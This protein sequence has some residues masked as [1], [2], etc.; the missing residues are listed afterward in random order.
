MPKADQLR[1][2]GGKGRG[3]AQMT[4][5]GLPVPPGFTI[6]TEV[7]AAF[8]QRGQW[9]AELRA[10]VDQA[11]GA[12]EAQTGRTF[13]R[14]PRPLLLSVRSGAATSMPGMM[15]TV[16]NLG[17]DQDT[18][19][20]LAAL[21]NDRR[22]ALDAYRRLL[23]MY[24]DVV[25]GVPHD[26]FERALTAAKHKAGRADMR[27]ADLPEPE[28]EAL[29][30]RYKK[31][32]AE[33]CGEPINEDPHAQ[34]WLAIAA[35][36]RSWNNTRA[37]RYRAMM[38]IEDALGTACTV[39]AMVFGNLG[40]RSG[41]G[42]AFT[43]NPSNGARELYGEF[44]TDAQGED[45]VAGLRTPQPL[46]ARAAMPG[47][48]QD[49]LE[50][51]I[52]EAFEALTG[53]LQMLESHYRDVQ[54]VEFTIEQGRVFV[55]QT[56]SAKRTPQAAV[57]AAV[58][59]VDEGMLDQHEAIDRVDAGSLG[60]LLHARLP[61]EDTLRAQGVTPIARGL[62]ASPG[63]GVGT[64]ALNAADAER[65]AAE[66]Q[67]VILVRRETSPE[68]V[69]G[70]LGA[71]AILTAA[72]GMTS[73]AAVVARGL[74]KCCVAGCGA[75]DIDYEAG[76]VRVTTD[77]R[78]LTLNE[79]EPITVDGHTGH[80]YKDELQ[81]TA[82]PVV[83]Q[84][85]TLM[86]WAD[87]R[88][89]MQVR[90]NADTPHGVRTAITY[91]AEG[92]GL[93][94]TEHMFF[95]PERLI[96]MRC[97]VLADEPEQRQPW[98]AKLEHMQ[99]SDFAEIFEAMA[100]K[101]VAIRLLDWPLHEFLPRTDDDFGALAQ[102]LGVSEAQVRAA[103]KRRQEI[104][105][106]LGH[107]GVRVGVSTPSIYEMQVA[108]IFGAAA[109]ALARG[110]E[111]QP[112][113]LLPFVAFESEVVYSRALIDRVAAKVQPEQQPTIDYAL[114]AM[115]ELPAAC[116][117]ADRLAKHVDFFSFG[118]NDLSQTTLGLSRDDS[119]QFIPSY[120][121]EHRL[122]DADPFAELDEASV[123]A[124]MT[125]AMQRAKATNPDLVVGMC[126]EH[127]G[128]PSSIAF[129]SE[130][131]LSYVSCS[132]PRLAVARLAAAQVAPKR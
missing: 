28:V 72:G 82:A 132:P 112:E 52:P 43:R 24:G 6:T 11:L 63:V 20:S 103:T 105:P 99:R 61:D 74:N 90:A 70:M 127:G 78:E 18:V 26:T 126:G 66:G 108:A 109:D 9:P 56:R 101:P 34:L 16:L 19:E 71:E 53:H 93:C 118:T 29:I 57:V 73:H 94:R 31:I 129:G 96:A 95:A 114:G 80:V 41:S 125:I 42:V 50:R 102:A 100:G 84:F 51:A 75:L 69:Q 30:A 5:I 25:L 104:N 131:G 83:A 40:S 60:Q 2:L 79:G 23:Q 123:G 107:R 97:A 49:T 62:P 91:G 58:T 45:V 48:E 13:G 44:L 14:G 89:H 87:E 92:I 122:L 67:R 77:G 46:A 124:L 7:G 33:H 120:V 115:I 37:E 59:M 68:D 81:V 121:T 54:D 110:I 128:Q 98:L 38:G 12:L 27:D 55:L 36:Y 4:A 119:G 21:H 111:T 116:L 8:R 10:Q 1:L 130:L 76:T 106:M 3:L 15:D 39:Q 86:R 88:R 117:I 35:V 47:K 22:F 113:I 17:L 64:I 32:I 85:D 65:R